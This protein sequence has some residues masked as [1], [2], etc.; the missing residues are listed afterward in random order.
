M[1]PLRIGLTGGVA[2]GKSTVAE[3]FATHGT[4][5][6]DMDTICHEL[7]APGGL[8]ED[9]VRKTFQDVVATGG[10]LDRTALRERVFRDTAS[11]SRLEAILHPVAFAKLEACCQEKVDAPYCILV[12]PLLVE[13]EAQDRV[14]R[15]LAINCRRE[16]Q[17]QRMQQRGLTSTIAEGILAAQ[18]NSGQRLAVADEHIDNNGDRDRLDAEVKKLH[19]KYLAV[20]RT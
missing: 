14:D 16:V 6:I 10:T 19:E 7:I 5:V 17:L 15:I 1:T 9:I 8:C 18:V 20:A 13:T 2:S 3:L 4:P 11:R 12:I